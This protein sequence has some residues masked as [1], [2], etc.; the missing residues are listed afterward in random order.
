MVEDL[1]DRSASRRVLPLHLLAQLAHR[2]VNGF[3]RY[4]PLAHVDCLAARHT[5][6]TER[7]RVHHLSE[8]LGEL[9][10]ELLVIIGEL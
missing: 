8:L 7:L 1:H 3:L 4:F 6:Q 10:G 2:H 5:L 9:L